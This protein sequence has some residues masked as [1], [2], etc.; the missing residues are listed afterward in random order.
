MSERVANIEKSIEDARQSL[1]YMWSK[2]KDDTQRRESILRTIISHMGA[3]IP[4]EI[5]G[6]VLQWISAGFP[7]GTSYGA[8]VEVPQRRAPPPRPAGVRPEKMPKRRK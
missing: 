3:D 1:P 4:D 7:G 5:I 2:S 8:P 6:G